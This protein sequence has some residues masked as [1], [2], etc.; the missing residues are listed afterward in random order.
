MYITPPRD[1]H[2]PSISLSPRRSG[3]FTHEIGTNIFTL[4]VIS[5]ISFSF[6]LNLNPTIDEEII[7]AANGNSFKHLFADKNI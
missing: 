6:Y 7:S 1:T 3:K 5:P 2:L 4:F